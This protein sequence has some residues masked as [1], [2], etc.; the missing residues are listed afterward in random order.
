M[1]YRK[2]T[3]QITIFRFLVAKLV[4]SER[5]LGL[6]EFIALYDLL[7]KLLRKASVD[8]SFAEKYENWLITSSHFL[9][10]LKQQRVFPVIL[11]PSIRRSVMHLLKPL[12]PSE[13]AYYGYVKDR[14]IMDSVRIKFRSP[15][16]PEGKVPKPSRVIGVG[17]R[18]KG[19]LRNTAIDGS[20][21]WQEVATSRSFQESLEISVLTTLL[22]KSENLSLTMEGFTLEPGEE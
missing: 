2:G 15:L 18:D 7:E 11:N 4:Y 20:P 21:R 5:G 17:Y 12:L 1:Y 10:R 19:Q 16:I 13:N 3:K 6:E 14:R 8:K 9:G 22:T